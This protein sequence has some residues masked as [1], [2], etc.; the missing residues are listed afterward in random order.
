VTQQGALTVLFGNLCSISMFES[1]TISSNGS[2]V[3]LYNNLFPI[4]SCDL[5]PSSQYIL[6]DRIPSC[7]R[8]VNTCFLQFKYLVSSAREFQAIQ[9]YWWA[10]SV[11]WN[12]FCDDDLRSS[13]VRLHPRSFCSFTALSMKQ[14]SRDQLID[15]TRTR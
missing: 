2:R 3:A 7:F 12:N 4:D 13:L 5:L 9:D 14:K 8:S 1:G 11:I 10:A 15:S 6:L